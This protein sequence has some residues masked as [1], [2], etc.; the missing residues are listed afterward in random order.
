[1]RDRVR[2]VTDPA[3]RAAEWFARLRAN[4]VRGR[5]RRAFEHWQSE[6]ADNAAAYAEIEE[7]WDSIGDSAVEDPIMAMRREAL[8]LAPAR[9]ERRWLPY[10]AIAASLV[11]VFALGAVLMLRAPGGSTGQTAQVAGTGTLGTTL[12]RTEVGERSTSRLPDGSVVQLNTDTVVR[13]AYSDGERLIELVRGEAVFEVAKDADR[14]FIVASGNERVIAHGTQFNVRRRDAVTEVTL[15][16]G[17][18]SVEREGGLLRRAQTAMLRPGQQ[19]V[20]AEDPAKAFV[21]RDAD[22]GKVVTW[23]DGRMSFD[24]EPLSSVI[25]EMNRYSTRKLEIAD[26]SLGALPVSGVFKTGSPETFAGALQASFPIVRSVDA[27]RDTIVLSWNEESRSQSA[28]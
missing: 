1:L 16:E 11:A 4:G 14:P 23:R 12:Y 2:L 26:P 8:A 19:L 24:G 6:A 22:V 9:P 25:A 21:V 7:L 27:K 17:K 5:E 18:V 20:A 28:R 13:V 10:G 3:A 15:I